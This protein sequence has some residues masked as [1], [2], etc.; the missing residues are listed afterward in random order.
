M[1]TRILIAALVT[2]VISPITFAQTQGGYGTGN[3]NQSQP[4]RN[5]DGFMQTQ[6]TTT[7]VGVKG[8]LDN[9]MANSKDNKFHATLSGMNLALTPLK[10]H[11]EK[12]LGGGK[13]TTAVDMKGADGKIYEIDFVTS[14]DQVTSAKIGKVNGKAP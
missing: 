3:V 2:S 6:T 8:Y 4:P 9:V 7:K 1:N 10:F 5:S 14:G 11:E 12:K 13:A